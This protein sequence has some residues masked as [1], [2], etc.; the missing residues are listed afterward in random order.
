M[1]ILQC[2]TSEN[3]H[4]YVTNDIQAIPKQNIRIILFFV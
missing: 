4:I 3:Y 2:K 1:F